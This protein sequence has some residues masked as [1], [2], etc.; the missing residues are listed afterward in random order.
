MKNL[1]N[2]DRYVAR[3]EYDEENDLFYGRV[4][5]IKDVIEF[6]ERLRQIASRV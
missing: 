6:Y 3:I 1:I 5:G 4:L 2:R